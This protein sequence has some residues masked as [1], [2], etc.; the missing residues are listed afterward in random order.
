V[1]SQSLSLSNTGKPS[2]GSSKASRDGSLGGTVIRSSIP[3]GMTKSERAVVV[4]QCL[5]AGLVAGGE[6][7]LIGQDD[8]PRAAAA[9]L[10]SSVSARTR[11]AR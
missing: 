7:D 10:P 3:S 5:A 2:V 11:M 4:L 1:K 8:K 6:I 9:E